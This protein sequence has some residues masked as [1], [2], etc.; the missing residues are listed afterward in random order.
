[1]GTRL[2]RR[3]RG[4]RVRRARAP[5]SPCEEKMDLHT[6]RHLYVSAVVVLLLVAIEI[7]VYFGITTGIERKLGQN[8]MA[9]LGAAFEPIVDKL[10]ASFAQQACSYLSQSS[11][12]P[13]PGNARI[14]LLAGGTAIAALL[15][16]GVLVWMML[17]SSMPQ[18]QK[19]WA[20]VEIA[21][22][23]VGFLAFDLFFFLYIVKGSEPVSASGMLDSVG[24]DVLDELS[25]ANLRKA[26]RCT[27]G[28]SPAPGRASP[29]HP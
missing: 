25:W 8:V 19:T 14:K 7:S 29:G 13:A 3:G 21:C 6:L 22:V 4:F 26:A 15:G 16:A 9:G 17:S 24:Q 1:M 10:P 28:P 20:L 12:A 23:A 2:R 11:N 5:L 18:E 27:G